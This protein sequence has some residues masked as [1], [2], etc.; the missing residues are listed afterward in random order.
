[1]VK[2]KTILMLLN[3][4]FLPDIRVEQEAD[5]LIELGYRVIII[6]SEKGNES[7]KYEI[8]RISKLPNQ[9]AIGTSESLFKIG[10]STVFR[11]QILVEL[12]KRG[13]SKIDAVHIHDLFWSKEGIILAQKF[14]AKV[15]IDLHENF[16][17]ALID[18]NQIKKSNILKA[19]LFKTL[20]YIL[21]TFKFKLIRKVI[22]ER[23]YSFENYMRYEKKMLSQCDAFIVVVDEALD[24]FKE[25]PFYSKGIVV[26][27]TKNVNTW[28][29]EEI[30]KIDG[31]IKICYMGSVHELRGV[32]TAVE[33]MSKVD[34]TKYELNI[35][36]L[37]RN[38]D[39]DIK[40]HKLVEKYQ[41]S[42]V[43]LIEWIKDE[44]IAY[45]YIRDSHICI[46][47]HKNTGLNQSTVPHKLFMY[48]SIGRPILVSDVAPLK[49]IASLAKNGL[50]FEAE[51]VADFASKLEEMSDLDLL[52]KFSKNGRLASELYFNWEMDKKRLQDVYKKLF[53]N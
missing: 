10:K 19:N 18:V 20:F 51:N 41:L 16:P 34:Q 47:P 29:Y 24:R 35:I 39:I 8:I 42:N 40:L 50:V 38:S 53:S 2:N 33:A 9:W 32:Q 37:I 31:V 43:N 17:E 13:I 27:N 23:T 11:K 4:G 1:M 22:L 15:I 14:K 6:A 21:K 46:V 44:D 52:C 49:R 12:T 48:M 3:Q 26:S 25:F 36:G 28:Y 45:Q 7:E 30:P 5:A